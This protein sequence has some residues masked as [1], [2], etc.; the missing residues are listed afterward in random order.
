MNFFLS[1]IIDTLM[2]D[3]M[4]VKDGRALSHIATN[5]LGK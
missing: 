1:I 2:V 4:L 3:Y 5:E